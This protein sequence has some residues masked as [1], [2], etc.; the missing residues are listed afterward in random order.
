MQ[1]S[2]NIELG[3]YVHVPFCST[4][5]DFCAFYQERPSKKGFEEYFLAL[6][7]DFHAHLTDRE[8][9]TVFIGGGTP[10]ILSEEQ[11]NKLC[12][13][14]SS[15]KIKDDCEWT[16]EVAPNEI[17]Q[18]KLDAFLNGGVNRL[19]L[20]VQTLDPVFMRELGRKHDVERAVKAYREVREAGFDNVNIDLL[21]GAPGQSLDHW[22]DDLR[23]A[24]DLAP[25]H[26]ST[27]CLTFE[28]DTALF[29]KL[30][31]GQIKLDPDREALFY[32]WAWEYL[33][34]QGY[35]QYEV[36]NYAKPGF[37]CRHNL[38]TWK[39]NEWIGYGPSASSQ[40]SQV[41]R[42][43]FSNI[44]QW[45][46]PL[47]L[48]NEQQYEEYTKLSRLEIAR[49]AILFGLRMNQGINLSDISAKFELSI[50]SFDPVVKFLKLL[51]SEGLGVSEKEY[52]FLTREGRIRCDA[53]ASE[54][55]ELENCEAL[56]IL[57]G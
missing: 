28:E 16:V 30:A 1:D 13:L 31:K 37:E 10:G 27:Y 53:I 49:D 5:C 41:R 20:G 46:K 29:A 50:N 38:N 33:P 47:L 14:I 40:F 57:S 56:G 43:N 35:N 19:S 36:S 21:F 24:V 34:D 44:E 45:A 51:E 52:Y 8:F 9:S 39:M 3:L 2:N 11:I 54:M 42:K 15:N 48:S 32:E 55:P 7:K 12:G 22:K 18:K 26:L 17:N 6:E 25:D 4:T 23:K